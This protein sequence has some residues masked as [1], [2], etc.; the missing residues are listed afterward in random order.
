M[1]VPFPLVPPSL[2][3]AGLGFGLGGSQNVV[4]SSVLFRNTICSQEWTTHAVRSKL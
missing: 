4:S 1:H 2:F 3:A